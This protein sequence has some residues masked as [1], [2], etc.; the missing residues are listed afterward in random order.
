MKNFVIKY[1]N[2]KTG[3]FLY[4]ECRAKSQSEALDT[5]F[6]TIDHRTYKMYD[7]Y[8]NTADVFEYYNIRG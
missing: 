2:L 5:M 7:V 4:F 8:M 3:N 1:I 6:E